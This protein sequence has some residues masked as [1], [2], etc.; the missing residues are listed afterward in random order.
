MK[1]ESI[2][3]LGVLDQP[4]ESADDVFASG[5]HDRVLLVISQDDHVLSLVVVALHQEGRDVVYIVDT[6]TQLAFL[7]KIVDTN[8]KRLATTGTS[9]VLESVA[10]G[11]TVAELLRNIGRRWSGSSVLGMVVSTLWKRKAVRI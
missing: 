6:S 2:I 11:G 8:E 9:G 5:N 3:G 4:A 7:T 1:E 10:F